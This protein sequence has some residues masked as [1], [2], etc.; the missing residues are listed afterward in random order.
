MDKNY[1]VN[2]IPSCVCYIL[3]SEPNK[4]CWIHGNPDQRQCPCCGLMRGYKACKRCGC[5]YGNPEIVE[6]TQ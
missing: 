3:A 4:H 6:D 2:Y 1:G 5:N